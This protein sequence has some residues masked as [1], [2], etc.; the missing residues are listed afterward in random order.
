MRDFF[1]NGL[2]FPNRPARLDR[3]HPLFSSYNQHTVFAGVAASGGMLDLVTRQVATN[4]NCL[5]GVDENGP[6]VSA[7]TG[8]GTG[9]L[10]FPGFGSGANFITM[11]MIFKHISTTRQYIFTVGTSEN[12]GW[13]FVTNSL[14]FLVNNGSRITVTLIPGHT[15]FCVM[16]NGPATSN[17]TMICFIMDMT[18]G[19]I[20]N[21][22]GP[23]CSGNGSPYPLDFFV[24]SSAA[25]AGE[26][27][28]AAFATGSTN[29]PPQVTPSIT[30]HSS[31]QCLA[32]L[33]NPWALFYA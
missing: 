2:S 5:S 24:P 8:S 32:L 9:T 23:A 30:F 31:D 1:R 18:T 14:E 16:T 4:T 10:Q 3:S 22:F 21:I 20:L 17:L 7:T 15:Y 27:I 29:T 33:S 19:Q 6:Y 12:T 11:G 13:F 25:V 26:R 28:Y